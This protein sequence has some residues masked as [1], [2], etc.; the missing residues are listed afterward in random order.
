M[1]IVFVSS[2]VVPFAKTGGLAD[3]SGALPKVMASLGNE[4]TII[5]P[6]YKKVDEEKFELEET[7]FVFY[8]PFANKKEKATI[9]VS[10]YLE[11]ITTYFVAHPLYF[12]RDELYGAASGAYSDNAERF[13]FF[14]KAVMELLKQWPA[15]PAIVSLAAAPGGRADGQAGCEAPRPLSQETEQK[16][17]QG[18]TNKADRNYQ[19]DILHCHDWQ[20]SLIPVYLKLE[21]Q[22]SSVK[23][24]YTIHNLA[25]QGRF[26]KEV[27]PLTGLPDELY[28]IDGLEYYGDVNFMKGGILFADYVTTVS[29]RYS[30]EILTPEYGCGLE[31]V[32]RVR[33]ERLSGILNG[34]DYNE[35]NPATDKFLPTNYTTESVEKKYLVK[36][37]LLKE[38]G[39]P[40]NEKIPLIGIISR[41]ADQKGFDILAECIDR[42]FQLNIQMII[43]GTGEE[44]YHQ[45][46]QSIKE[47]HPQRLTLVLGF[48]NALAHRIYAGADFFLMPS[49][50]EPCGLGQMIALKYGTIPIVHATGGLAD[51]IQN[52]SSEM[53][54]GNGFS[55]AEYS[56]ETL[57][58]AV[59]MAVKVYENKEEWL[60][61]IKKG[62]R[63]DFSWEV[64][65]RKY[66][67]LYKICLKSR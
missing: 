42:I 48:D 66:L 57:L 31:G 45:L 30:K 46:F 11:N 15:T 18:Q 40:F 19:P 33:Q 44:K 59:K 4:V 58:Q 65:A 23:S 2:E 25:Y 50:Y 12:D 10:K 38:S 9:K 43:L 6:K 37:S 64:S 22:F 8:I 63:E 24:V 34:I 3:V 56:S 52:Y 26:T 55:F 27:F 54:E 61:L 14:S 36:E 7:D 41:L 60:G 28:S 21:S 20:T 67:E 47:R 35:W 51:T 53:K 13:I 49:L 62:M 29:Q 1:K 32:L 17:R 5:L 16:G 39:L